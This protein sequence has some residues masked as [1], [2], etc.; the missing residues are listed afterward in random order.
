MVKEIQIS[1]DAGNGGVD[2]VLGKTD[3]YF[4]AVRSSATGDRLNIKMMQME[5]VYNTWG[6]MR[7]YIGD[8]VLRMAA[9]SPERHQGA[10]RYGNEFHQHLVAHACAK[11]GAGLKG[12]TAVDLT[13]FAP[14]GLY[15]VV[16]DVIERN[17]MENNG[18]VEIAYSDEDKPR[19][20]NYSRVKV[21]PEGIGAAAALM[22]DYNGL[23]K[24]EDMF[25]GNV[26][27]LD[28]GV[29]TLD[30]VTLHDGD[31]NAETLQ[32]ATWEKDGLRK[33]VLEPIL[34]EIRNMGG[35]FSHVTLDH[36]DA[37]LRD[38]D[39]KVRVSSAITFD[40]TAR[41]KVYGEKYAAWAANTI[42]DAQ[43]DAGN[44]SSI[45]IPMGGWIDLVEPHLRKWYGDKIFDRS[46]HPFASKVH[47]AYWNAY[48]GAILARLVAAAN[49]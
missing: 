29:H 15:N 41:L 44:G 43:L 7:W 49:T 46:K 17:F 18:A 3:C 1:V 10:N 33:H 39:H 23:P 42:I 4:P 28:G 22:F 20:W 9:G 45:L 36:I 12:K 40:I 19:K 24:W 6:G 38:P 8:E 13:L 2:A 27:L 11:L 30:V 47:P 37:A 14:P 48:G 32:S 26:T 21:W 34:R 35:D 31:F 16:A 5:A 25:R